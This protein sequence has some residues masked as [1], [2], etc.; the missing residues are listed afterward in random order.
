MSQFLA[1]V[2]SAATSIRS[3]SP[4]ASLPTNKVLAGVIGGGLVLAAQKLKITGLPEGWSEV[5]GAAV[6]AYLFPESPIAAAHVVAKRG[7]AN[8]QRAVKSVRY[9]Q[10]DIG[11]GT[12]PQNAVFVGGN[13]IVGA[14]ES[15]APR[16]SPDGPEQPPQ[17]VPPAP[18]ATFVDGSPVQPGV[19]APYVGP[20][21]A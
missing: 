1:V 10:A 20:S 9:E 19:Q 3:S 13:Q 5:A 4:G 2:R 15:Y 12:K 11:E 17:S 14:A 8:V 18:N 7:G 6:A 21:Q 16:P